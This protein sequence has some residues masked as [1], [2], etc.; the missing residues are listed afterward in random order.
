MSTS[1]LTERL[2][3]IESALTSCDRPLNFTEAAHFLSCSPSWLYKLTHK[4]MVPHSK[5]GGKR[6][7]F[8]RA[9]LEAFLLSNRVATGAE[10]DQAATDRLACGGR[11]AA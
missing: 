8:R 9:D 3:R 2:D 5:P 4:R 7:F 11:K 10:I 1:A 6:L